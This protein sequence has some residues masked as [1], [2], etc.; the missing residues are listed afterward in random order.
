MVEFCSKE[1]ELILRAESGDWGSQKENAGDYL[2]RLEQIDPKRVVEAFSKHN[3]EFIHAS[4]GGL[5]GTR[6][7]NIN[8]GRHIYNQL[9]MP[10]GL[11]LTDEFTEEPIRYDLPVFHIEGASKRRMDLSIGY[12]F[13][14]GLVRVPE[15][16]WQLE[17]RLKTMDRS[18]ASSTSELLEKLGSRG[19]DFERAFYEFN[20]LKGE[21]TTTVSRV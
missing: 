13:T 11:P 2:G 1:D 10:I 18:L 15:N 9:T 21:R 17:W 8:Q 7:S 19:K 4:N 3:F 14:D 5:Y 20:G 12:R 6:T 16:T